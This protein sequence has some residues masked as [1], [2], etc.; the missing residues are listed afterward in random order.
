MTLLDEIKLKCTPEEIASKEHGLI[1]SK[2]SQGRVAPNAFEIGNGTILEVLGLTMGNAVL[3]A[4]DVTPD[5]KYVK[6]LLEQ[7]RLRA[8]SPLVVVACAGFVSAGLMTQ[9]RADALI[10]LGYSPAPVSVSEVIEAMKGI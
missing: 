3:A 8:A 7:G 10:A 2:V 6:P 9:E 4:I 5:F 1:A